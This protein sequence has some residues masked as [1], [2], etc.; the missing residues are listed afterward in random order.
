MIVL[1]INVEAKISLTDCFWYLNRCSDLSL[2]CF[3]CLNGAYIFLMDNSFHSNGAKNLLSGY[4]SRL[5]GLIKK[6]KA[7]PDA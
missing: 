3:C 1:P 4:T 2:D 6:L 7:S 5:N